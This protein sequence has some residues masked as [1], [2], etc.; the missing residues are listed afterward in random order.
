L[1]PRRPPPFTFGWA[2][3]GALSIQLTQRQLRE[4]TSLIA[5]VNR[6][7]ASRDAA[8]AEIQARANLQ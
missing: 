3:G 1:E 8:M 5:E 4:A 6:L 2:P 7:F